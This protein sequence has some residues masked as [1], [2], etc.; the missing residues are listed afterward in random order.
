MLTSTCSKML[1][2]LTIP[3]YV[4]KF[5]GFSVAFFV[6]CLGFV[7]HYF[8]FFSASLAGLKLDILLANLELGVFS[9]A[10]V[11]DSEQDERKKNWEERFALSSKMQAMLRKRDGLEVME[12]G[13]KCDE[14]DLEEVLGE[15][16]RS[17]D[18]DL[19]EALGE[20][21]FHHHHKL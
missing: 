8:L 17:N 6:C 11:L 5:S 13:H 15:R 19:E 16:R 9:D 18:L 21:T 4:L 12:E 14:L 10:K 3:L 1:W 7:R 20:Q 2:T